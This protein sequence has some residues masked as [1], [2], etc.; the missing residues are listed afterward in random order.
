MNVRLASHIPVA[1][2]AAAHALQ[3]AELCA[4]GLLHGGK[5]VSPTSNGS[6]KSSPCLGSLDVLQEPCV[7]VRACLSLLPASPPDRNHRAVKQLL[8]GDAGAQL[9]E[10]GPAEGEPDAHAL[11]HS[12]RPPPHVPVQHVRAAPQQRPHGGPGPAQRLRGAVPAAPGAQ[13][14]GPWMCWIVASLGK[15]CLRV[16]LAGTQER[17]VGSPKTPEPLGGRRNALSCTAATDTNN[18]LAVQRQLSL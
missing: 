15:N 13:L 17:A 4:A 14:L 18:H 12:Q 5:A 7:S 10:G 6:T 1:G 9:R 8:T 16:Y 2:L 11:G 3:Q